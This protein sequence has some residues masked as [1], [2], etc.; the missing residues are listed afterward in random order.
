MSEMHSCPQCG[1]ILL[2]DSNRANI[3]NINCPACSYKGKISDFPLFEMKNVFC[4][5]CKKS[6]KI[7]KDIKGSITCPVCKKSADASSFLSEMTNDVEKGGTAHNDEVAML[8][9][10]GK[11][12]C[13]SET[14]EYELKRGANS[15]GRL[16]QSST[17]SIQISTSDDFMS[18]N[19]AGI[20]VVMNSNSTFSHILFDNLS[21]NGTFHNGNRL[22]QH[23]RIYLKSC[24]V[25]RLGHTIFNFIVD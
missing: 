24:D 14:G 4:P 25:I 16:H 2:F 5:S 18:R 13:V 7:G 17:A 10:V 20:D 23:D 15:I 19:H 3:Q 8:Y 21:R 12:V 9:R 22:E 6:L 11:L 1:K